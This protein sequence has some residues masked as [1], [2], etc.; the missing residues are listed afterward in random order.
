MARVS[1]ISSVRSRYNQGVPVLRESFT[2]R[3]EVRVAPAQ[4]R[5]LER[6]A[7][8]RQASGGRFPV[9]RA[10]REAIAEWIKREAWRTL[11]GQGENR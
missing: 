10:V 6:I 3:L 9:S 4:M 2:E 1:R 7:A 5:Q 11:D 8:A